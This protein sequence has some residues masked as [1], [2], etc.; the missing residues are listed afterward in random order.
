VQR[1]SVDW[2]SAR[3]NRN[4]LRR[5]SAAVAEHNHGQMLRV[6]AVWG[7]GVTVLRHLYEILD[8][9]QG[10]PCDGIQQYGW[11]WSIVRGC[12][13]RHA[14][15]TRCRMPLTKKSRGKGVARSMFGESNRDRKSPSLSFFQVRL[16]CI[17]SEMS[18]ERAPRNVSYATCT[19]PDRTRGHRGASPSAACVGGNLPDCRAEALR[20]APGTQRRTRSTVEI[21]YDDARSACVCAT[22]VC[23]FEEEVIC[24]KPQAR[25]SGLQGM[26][27]RAEAVGGQLE[28]RSKDGERHSRGLEHACRASVRRDASPRSGMSSLLYPGPPDDGLQP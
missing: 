16:T 20:N 23:A 14:A 6:K 17:S 19:T 25:H 10:T 1:S 26:R 21:R 12:R 5:R 24:N 18:W 7:R 22:T 15:D 8:R 9:D 11:A 2:V 28:V 4:G 27:E 3:L 13:R